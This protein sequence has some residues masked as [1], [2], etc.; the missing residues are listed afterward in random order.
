MKALPSIFVLLFA[1]SAVVLLTSGGCTP[2]TP[3][4]DDGDGA[5]GGNGGGGNGGGDGDGDGGDDGTVQAVSFENQ[6]QPI[7]DANC[8]VCHVSGGIADA[9]MHLNAEE[10]FDALVGQASVQDA[11]L[12]RVVA[13]DS[14]TSLL[15]EKVSSNSP[16]V[17]ARMPLGGAPLSDADIAL[18]GDWIDEGAANN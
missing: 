18:I 13:G 16:P 17:G 9:I 15:F 5:G 7:F 8:T 2:P 6:I 1:V 14:G 11:S 3:A 4:A 10:S 12:T